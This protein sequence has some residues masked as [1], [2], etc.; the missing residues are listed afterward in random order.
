MFKKFNL[1]TY[2]IIFIVLLVIVVITLVYKSYKGDRSYELKI[3]FKPE[4][5]TDIIITTKANIND[6]ITFKLKNKEWFV[7]KGNLSFSADSAKVNNILREL[8]NMKAQ[9]VAAIDNS[10]WKEYEVTDSTG[11]RVIVKNK[12][13][14]IA[15]VFIG[16]FSYQNPTNY[17]QYQG[18]MTT[19]VRKAD[20]DIIYAVDGFLRMSFNSDLNSYRNTKIVPAGKNDWAKLTFSYPADS[21]F[22]LRKEENKWM[23]DGII[24]DSAKVAGYLNSLKRLTSYYFIDDT[25]N[26]SK[27]SLFKLTI[28]DEDLPEPIVITAST[29][30]TTHMYAIV[31]SVNK[32][33]VFS[34][35]MNDLFKKIFTS[36]KQ[37]LGQ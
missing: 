12:N 14:K 10:K 5:V 6:E 18:T 32:G 22:V 24:A 30:D 25:M 17:Y 37:L 19:F 31:S 9:R 13:K 11:V 29:A 16:K 26:I 20:E 3:K 27:N 33:N 8:K 36:K 28:E 34:G 23:I 4:K 15:D 21:S 2:G 7:E 1:K 35:K